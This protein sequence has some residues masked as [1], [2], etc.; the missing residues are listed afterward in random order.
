[1]DYLLLDLR[2][3]KLC[4][5]R[6]IGDFH[7]NIFVSKAEAGLRQYTSTGTPGHPKH[8][9]ENYQTSF[10][11][12]RLDITVFAQK[13]KTELIMVASDMVVVCARKRKADR[14]V[15]RRHNAK[16]QK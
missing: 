4:R 10:A 5:K 6:G 2:R 15:R 16:T 3:S 12:V 14:R 9:R 11:C 13:T 7:F 8:L 1:M